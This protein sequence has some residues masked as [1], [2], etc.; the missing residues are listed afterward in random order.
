MSSYTEDCV[1]C[2]SKSTLEWFPFDVGG[3]RD[4][5]SEVAAEQQAATKQQNMFCNNT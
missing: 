5:M 4:F 1:V 3:G 2:P